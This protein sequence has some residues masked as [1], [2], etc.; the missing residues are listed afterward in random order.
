MAELK[1]NNII[2]ENSKTIFKTFFKVPIVNNQKFPPIVIKKEFTKEYLNVEPDTGFNN[3]GTQDKWISFKTHKKWCNELKK[4]IVTGYSDLKFDNKY[5]LKKI[6]YGFVTGS[7]NGVLIMDLDTSK[8][9][10]K[11]MGNNHPFISHYC[12]VFDIKPCDNFYDTIETIVYKLNTFSVKTPSGGFHIYFRIE[13]NNIRPSKRACKLEIDIKAES[14]Y[15]VGFNSKTDKGAYSVFTDVSI[16]DITEMEDNF[17]D[18]VYVYDKSPEKQ[19]TILESK[20]KKRNLLKRPV[21]MSLW[22]YN[23]NEEI[24]TSINV[25]IKKHQ[26]KFF[27]SKDKD[28]QYD[29]YFKITTFF[30]MFNKKDLWIEY[31]KKHNGYDSARN[32]I[33]WDN[34]NVEEA[35]NKY[36]P[37]C[38][39]SCILCMI[40][41]MYLLPLIKYRKLTENVIKPDLNVN[42]QNTKGLAEVLELDHNKNYVIQSGTRSGKT[43]LVNKYHHSLESTP[44]LSIVSRTSLAQEHQRVFLKMND[45]NDDRDYINYADKRK[46]NLYQYEGQNLIIQV[47]SLNKIQNYDF[48]EYIIFIDELQSVFEYLD[49][50]STLNTKRKEIEGIFIKAIKEC[51]QFIG[52]DA[53]IQDSVLDFL[54]PK[55]DKFKTVSPNIK[56][57][58]VKNEFC[59]YENIEAEEVYSYDDLLRLIALEEK[60]MVCCDSANESHNLKNSLLKKFPD[61]ADTWN[62]ETKIIDRLYEGDM[63][64]DKIECLIF[65][66]KIIYG[67]DSTMQRKVFCLFKGYTIPAKS[68]LQQLSRCRSIE[69]VYFHF[70]NKENI[71][72]D[73]EFNNPNEVIDRI[74]YLDKYSNKIY[75]KIKLSRDQYYEDTRETN[76]SD[77]FYN[78]RMAKHLYNYDSDRTNKYYHFINGLKKMKIKVLTNGISKHYKQKVKEAKEVKEMTKL[79]LEEHFEN[80]LDKEDYQYYERINDILKIPKEEWLKDDYKQLFINPQA[81][82]NHLNFCNLVLNIDKDQENKFMKNMKLN[83]SVNVSWSDENRVLWLRNLMIDLG[84]VSSKNLTI[85]KKLDNYKKYQNEYIK[86]FRD[87]SKDIDFS[88]EKQLTK[89]IKKTI[90]NLTGEKLY[91][92]QQKERTIDKKRIKW[93]E[94]II[95]EDII[96]K[97]RNILKY[98]DTRLLN[99]QCL[100]ID[101][102]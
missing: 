70:M 79:E 11:I 26:N 88:C 19:K 48:S 85:T 91:K 46:E 3:V 54:N 44:I 75:D 57:E 76:L 24:F 73:F 36:Q 2:M 39:V 22:E 25:G 63:D 62:I 67:L 15:V 65:S 1:Y 92:G 86:L 40:G 60:F 42:S 20:N 33:I 56:Y 4:D 78:H 68:M 64:L 18:I 97:N 28:Y 51:K 83:Y 82:H 31:C 58:F 61:M 50:S 81:I 59:P 16:K 55:I 74:H 43:F 93:T 23:M 53:D 38:I 37:R 6:N 84:V 30:K 35:K 102:D 96:E 71:V 41:K 89:I 17:L 80:N 5:D 90:E 14:G 66:P 77:E 27:N 34:I 7:K 45:E 32:N 29:N 95:Q 100:I 9:K 10:W 72:N 87:R 49:L 94:Y 52:V 101:E 13:K 21:D 47:D 69:K 99:N 8:D 12:R 98:R